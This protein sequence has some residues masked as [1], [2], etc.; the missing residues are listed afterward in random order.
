MSVDFE[1]LLEDLLDSW[2]RNN[3][4]LVNLLGALPAGGLGVSALPGS[5]T[6]AQLFTHVH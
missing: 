2:D 5:P 1:D 4:I 3:R 6:V